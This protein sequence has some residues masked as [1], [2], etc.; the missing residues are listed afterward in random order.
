MVK[1]NTKFDLTHVK[2]DPSHCLAPGLFRSLRR[3]ERKKSKLDVTYFIGKDETM[4]FIG[5]EPLGADDMRLLQGLVAFGGPHGLVLT[6]DP[7]TDKGRQ[8]RLYLDPKM[9]AADSDGMV[10]KENITRL[11]TEIGLTDGSDNIKALK[12]SLTRMSNVTVIVTRGGRQASFHLMSHALDEDDGKIFVALNPL[13]TS[14]I[15]GRTKHTQI[16]MAEVRALRTSP[17]RLIHQRLCGWI[18]PGKAGRAEMDTLSTYIWPD[19]A[20]NPNT[21]KT[22]RQTVRRA[23]AELAGLGWVVDEYATAKFNIKRP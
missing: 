10:V 6:S 2:H 7:K 8:L 13:I 14:A 3:G 19:Q 16:D 5:F 23:L 4:R 12:A 20:T 1:S 9:E 22:R 18:D 11:L 17:A 21:I 15:L